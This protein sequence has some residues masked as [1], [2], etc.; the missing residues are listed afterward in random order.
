ML[1]SFFVLVINVLEVGLL[2]LFDALL[3]V[4]LLLFHL[5]LL[6]VVLNDVAHAIHDGLDALA[7]SG[8]SS[9]SVLLLLELDFHVVLNLLCISFLNLLDLSDTFALLLH[10]LFD[11]FHCSLAFFDFLGRFVSAFLL[12][13]GCKFSYAALLLILAILLIIN[14]LLLRLLEHDVTHAFLFNDLGLKV[15]LLLAFSIHLTLRL[16][17]YSLV[18]VL[19]FVFSLFTK[20][21]PKLNLLIKHVTNLLHTVD[22]IC[23]L[24]SDLLLV[25]FLAELLDL[26]PLV[27]ADIGRQVLNLDNLVSTWD[28]ACFSHTIELFGASGSSDGALGGHVFALNHVFQ[29]FGQSVFRLHRVGQSVNGV[30]LGRCRVVLFNVGH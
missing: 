1:R 27:I 8:H 25:E 15:V 22:M 16:F 13:L 2:V 23:L 26:T 10:V 11:N 24:L 4:L 6:V 3:Y 19:S 12:D 18:K 14:L 21:G 9:L 28:P 7:T 30:T 5:H 20:L 17:K 29:S